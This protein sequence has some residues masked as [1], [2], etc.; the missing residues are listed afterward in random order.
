MT[1]KAASA[2]CAG[3]CVASSTT[4]AGYP[5]S[6]EEIAGAED[7]GYFEAAGRYAP[8]LLNFFQQLMEYEG[9][10]PDEPAVLG[11]I[12]ARVLVLH[13]SDTKPFL[14]VSAQYVADH[15]PSARMHEIPG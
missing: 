15:V 3:G 11:A 14:A 6:D 1:A 4:A 7:A 10:M 5:F 8:N 13:G 9:P 2:S 12:S